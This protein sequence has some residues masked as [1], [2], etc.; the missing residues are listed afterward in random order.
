MLAKTCSKSALWP[1]FCLLVYSNLYIFRVSRQEC[2]RDISS[3]SLLFVYF[4]TIKN[5]KE[6]KHSLTKIGHPFSFMCLKTS[7]NEID[8][9]KISSEKEFFEQELII[10]YKWQLNK[11]MSESYVACTT[12]LW[13]MLRSKRLFQTSE[14]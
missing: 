6:C 14:C 4:V 9:E 8:I 12:K 10:H 1:G 5:S 13:F 3:F 7:I 2:R 11:L